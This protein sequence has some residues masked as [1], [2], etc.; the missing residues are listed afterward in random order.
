[1]GDHVVTELVPFGMAKENRLGARELDSR[2]RLAI[3]AKR[4][5]DKSWPLLEQLSMPTGSSTLGTANCLCA[6]YA[7]T[8]AIRLARLPTQI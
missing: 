7:H 1:M 4:A 3:I 6:R 2:T 5:T 8:A